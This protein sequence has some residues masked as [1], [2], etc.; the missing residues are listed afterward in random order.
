MFS[1]QFFPFGFTLIL[2]IALA[3]LALVHKFLRDRNRLRLRE[4]AHQERIAAMQSNQ[5]LPEM[6]PSELDRT[7]GSHLSMPTFEQSVHWV[8]LTALG[9][10]LFLATTGVGMMI[11]FSMVGDSELNRIWAVGFLPLFAGVGLLLFHLLTTGAGK[12]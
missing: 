2:V 7:A 8:R 3:A 11:G 5:P 6:P 4:M 1:D 10:G 9:L 12:R